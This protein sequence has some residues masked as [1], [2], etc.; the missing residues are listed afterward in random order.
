MKRAMTGWLAAAMLI[1]LLPMGTQA[2]GAQSAQRATDSDETAARTIM[3]YDCGADLEMTAGMA[4]YNLRQILDAEFSEGDHVKFLVM[5]GGTMKWYL[6][7]EYLSMPAELVPDGEPLDKI[8]CNYNQIWEAKGR[9]ASENAGKMV[10]LDGDGITTDTPVLSEDELMSDPETLKAFIN[11]C[12]ARYPADKYDLILWDHGGGPISGFGQDD[13]ANYL[14]KRPMSFSEIMDALADNE[15]TAPSGG[16][17]PG[18]FDLINFDACMMNSIEL[19]AVLS[20]FT[21]YYVASPEIVPGYGQSYTG[22]LNILGE[23][24]DFDTYELGK[25]IV[26][27]YL[28]FYEN[29]EGRGENA[30]L[31]LVDMRKLKDSGIFEAVAE[32]AGL[33]KEEAGSRLFYDELKSVSDSIG[34]GEEMFGYYDLGNLASL[35]T[36]AGSEVSE[37][38]LD[39]G[40]FRD[41]NVYNLNRITQKICGV[42]EDED[43]VYAAGTHGIVSRDKII[44]SSSDDVFMSD[45]RTSGMH[46]YFAFSEYADSVMQYFDE[47]GA[48]LEKLPD[49]GDVRYR[50]LDN[51]RNAMLDYALV[52]ETGFAVTYLVNEDKVDKIE[53]GL[54]KVR[55]WMTETDDP[56]YYAVTTW[57]RVVQP[58]IDRRNASVTETEEWLDGVIRQQAEEAVS[59]QNISASKVIAKNGKGFKVY[60]TD[61]RKRAVDSVD[62]VLTFELPVMKEYTENKLTPEE[63]DHFSEAQLLAL[64]RQKGYLYLDDKYSGGDTPE[65]RVMNVIRWYNDMDSTWNLDAMESKWYA[66]NDS[67]GK[68]HA[69]AIFSEDDRAISILTLNAALDEEKRREVPVI[70]TFTKEETGSSRL[71]GIAFYENTGMRPINPQELTEPLTLEP[72]LM[73]TFMRNTR[74]YLPVSESPVVV[75]AENAD[76][77]SLDYVDISEIPDIRDSDGDGEVINSTFAV[78][79]IYGAEF[80][81]TDKV[82]GAEDTLVHIE[83]AEVQPAVYTGEKLA[84]V[85]VYNGETLTEGTDYTWEPLDV[86]E[87]EEPP[88]YIEP[89]EYDLYLTGTG[90]FTGI[91]VAKFRIIEEG[92]KLP[93]KTAR[94]DMF[95]LAGNVKVTWKAVPGARYYKVYREGVTDPSESVSEPVIV[96]SKLVGWDKSPGLTD[97]HAYR[98]K[99]VASLTGKGDPSGDSPQSYSKIMYRLKNVPILSAKNTGAGKVTVSFRKS[100]S[101]DSYVL[102]WSGN[103]D[104]SGAK[105]KV[106]RGASNTSCVIGG[107]KKGKT[108]YFSIRVRKV[109]DGISYYTTFGVAKKVKVTQ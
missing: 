103:E 67:E 34:Y 37:E 84:P 80:D 97:G 9:D 57:G 90:R 79:D 93:G 22:W 70:L 51:Y 98:Y 59:L 107:L 8:S 3:L 4:S 76:S 87:G 20:E 101:G 32:L 7:S 83:M 11:Y 50:L 42:L 55:E 91:A 96:T 89:G 88:Q 72:A 106:V 46:I 77:I 35:I 31:A 27:D 108:Y 44:R 14:S 30:T 25:R 26:D 94:G 38:D 5:T 99:I 53:I 24:P 73:A 40:T 10:L 82:A 86:P 100:A 81:I 102:Q 69:A 58:M 18:R 21:D 16:E 2:R 92:K 48:V 62:R 17:G 19:N 65:E 52:Y 75:S 6:E 36:V 64:G 68:L 109:V 33:M 71:S 49:H 105:T 56:E 78:R 66:V 28:S 74:F 85:L 43:I 12:V 39:K 41:T 15:V 60:I 63:A 29:G 47:I 95:N 13:H 23:F 61:S 104:M 54:D 1:A 45:L